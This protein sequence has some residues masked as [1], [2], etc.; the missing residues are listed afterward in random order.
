M[1]SETQSTIDAIAKSLALIRLRLDRPASE[2][3]LDELNRTS[4][5]PDLWNDPQRAQKLMKDRQLLADAIRSF[6]ELDREFTDAVELIELAEAEGDDEIVAEAEG[7]LSRL[8]KTAQKREIDALL[9]GEA[10]SNDAFLEINAGAGGTESCD[11]AAMLSRMYEKWALRRSYSHELISLNRDVEAGF[12]SV[13][14]KFS[15]P[16]AYGWL[17]TE[18]GVHRLVRNSPFDSNSRRHTS[19]SSVWVYPAIDESIEVEIN[20][21]DLR[22][23]T[24]RA[25]GAGGQ[26]VNKTDSAVRITHMP[27]GIVVTSSEKSQHQNRANCMNALRSR[28]YELEL[29]KRTEQIQ[30]MHSQKGDAGWGNQIRSYVLSP[31]QMVKDL[32]TSQETSDTQGVL[33]GNIDDFMASVLARNVTGMTRAEAAGE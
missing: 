18:S 26:H 11:W 21:A 22:V 15:G 9:S 20:P 23:D 10:D 28:L 3:R 30:A 14:H 25:S 32:R 12:K 27:T 4:E 6:D 1:R 24:F 7:A 5:D 8:L 16:N 19:F 2:K 17:K 33:D 29:R 13:T 31:Y